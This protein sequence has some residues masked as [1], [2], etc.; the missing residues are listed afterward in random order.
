MRNLLKS[1]KG[2]TLVEIVI[3]IAI[4][5]IMALTLIPA[6][7]DALK[8]RRLS[9]AEEK[10]GKVAS[11]MLSGIESGKIPTTSD[12]KNKLGIPDE[13][14]KYIITDD[15]VKDPNGVY[16]DKSELEFLKELKKHKDIY[17]KFMAEP[18]RTI[19]LVEMKLK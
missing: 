16:I 14:G 17:Y 6:V 10:A 8:S 5:G 1:K 9:L 4:I 11:L 18:K 7:S 2:F 15:A 19:E 3:V 13:E 12:Q